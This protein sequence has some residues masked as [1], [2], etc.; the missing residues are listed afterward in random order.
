VPRSQAEAQCLSSMQCRLP[1]PCPA[2]YE[3]SDKLSGLLGHV[4]FSLA[5]S[6]TLPRNLVRMEATCQATQIAQGC[7]QRSTNNC[8]WKNLLR[9]LRQQD[10]ARAF[11]QVS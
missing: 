2:S 9:C 6:Q 5:P 8:P 11:G 4:L 3:T 1:G 7:S 10:P